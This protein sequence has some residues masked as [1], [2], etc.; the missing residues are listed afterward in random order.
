[1]VLDGL[2]PLEFGGMMDFQAVLGFKVWDNA[3]AKYVVFLGVLLGGWIVGHLV[4]A[5][6]KGKIK[7][8]AERTE[9]KLDD[10]IVGILGGPVV[11]IVFL[12]GMSMGSKM[13][14]GG[15]QSLVEQIY[16]A[17]VFFA[18]G[19][20]VFRTIDGVNQYYLAPFLA[21]TETKVDDVLVPVLLR[22]V[23]VA[24]A[25]FVGLLGLEA[26][27][28]GVGPI[29]NFLLA[30][31]IMLTATAAVST[32]WL[33][34]SIVGGLLL[35]FNKPFVEG[36]RIAF[37]TWEGTVEKL[38]IHRILLKVSDGTVVSVPN[39]E[40]VVLPVKVLDKPQST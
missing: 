14:E 7:K 40:F 15:F 1:V 36:D 27:G 2:E 23:K 28:Y 26:F 16:S 31:A 18:A 22:A 33:L 12:V 9:T 35:L 13:M 34:R 25:I 30:F 21:K 4:N 38:E 19:W 8:L 17:L 3:I 20:V 6:I 24:V 32:V 11:L 37:G 5:L 29:V 10:L 39:H